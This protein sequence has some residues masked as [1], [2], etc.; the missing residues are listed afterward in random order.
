MTGKHAIRTALCAGMLVAGAGSA[1]ALE[2][3]DLVIVFDNLTMLEGS[4]DKPWKSHSR[5]DGIAGQLA[6]RAYTDVCRRKN[7]TLVYQ[8]GTHTGTVGCPVERT[9]T[10]NAWA[11]DGGTLTYTTS[12]AVAGN[13]VT[14]QG[15]MTGRGTDERNSCGDRIKYEILT[16]VTQTLKVRVTGNTCQ[17]LQYS[18]ASVSTS[19]ETY[20]SWEHPLTT[21]VSRFTYRLAPNAKCSVRRRS[22]MPV[23]PPHEP[24]SISGM[25]PKC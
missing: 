8:P 15:K 23:V 16:E 11:E 24:G 14:L 5:I 18:E 22:E 1:R 13:I 21:K 17:V 20:K 2:L 7:P 3:K 4:K 12:M 25:V 9:G 10:K 6:W 19:R